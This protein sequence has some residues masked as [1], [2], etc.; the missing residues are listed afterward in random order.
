MVGKILNIK[1]I[2]EDSGHFCCSYVKG[3][4]SCIVSNSLI[5]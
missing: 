5:H 1:N 4:F 3:L 2:G